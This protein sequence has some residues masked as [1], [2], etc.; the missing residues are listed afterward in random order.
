MPLFAFFVTV[1]FVNPFPD[2]AMAPRW[3]LLSL[4]VPW[5]LWRLR[6]ISCSWGVLFLLLFVAWGAVT[7]CWSPVIWD[8]LYLWWHF[9]LFAALVVISAASRVDMRKVYVAM[10]LGLVLNSALVLGQIAGSIELNQTE[11]PGGLFFNRNFWFEASALVL[12]GLLAKDRFI[13]WIIAVPLVLPMFFVP[14]ARAAL[15]GLCAAS[16]LRIWSY[17]RFAAVLVAL[18][19]V[20]VLVHL[21]LLPGRIVAGTQR[22]DLWSAIASDVTFWGNGLGATRFASPYYEYAHNDLLQTLYETGV[23]GLL[24]L[25]AFFVFCLWRGEIRERCVAAAFVTIGCFGFPL[26]LPVTT[27][28][29]ALAL[30]ALCR[31]R[32]PVRF[33]VLGRQLRNYAWA[34]VQFCHRSSGALRPRPRIFSIEAVV[35]PT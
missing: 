16:C 14:P 34:V 19:T 23:P 11:G 8:G 21:I 20:G 1:A 18:V 6:S 2:G 5:L 10:A 4:V 30:G 15:M 24:L 22:L 9:A 29:A 28:L 12:V 7:L 17:S 13:Q 33:H 31:D 35:S 3:A 27:F 32:A 25:G 26:Y